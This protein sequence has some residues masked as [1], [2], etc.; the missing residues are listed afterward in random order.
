MRHVCTL[1][2]LFQ[3]NQRYPLVVAANRD[4]FLARPAAPPTALRQD[5]WVIAGQDLLAGGTW[6]GVSQTGLVAG[7]LNRRTARPIDPQRRSRGAL[8]MDALAAASVEAAIS[9]VTRQPA[10]AYNPFNLLVA[11]RSG[12]AVIGNMSGDMVVQRLTPGVHLLTNLDLDDMECPRIA[13]SFALFEAAAHHLDH[14]DL[15]ALLAELP[16]ILSDHSTPLDPRSAGPPNN[17]CVHTDR[18][19]TRSSCMVVDTVTATGNVRRLWFADG[20]PC[21]TPFQE[22]VLPNT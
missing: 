18:Y 22:V 2:I 3:V 12:A 15:P 5:P 7:L 17:L 9:A 1:A 10:T 6:F 14:E 8:C 20:P 4:E 13:K 11:S 16:K 21:R 19:G